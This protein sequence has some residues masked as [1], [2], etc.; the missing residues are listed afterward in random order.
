MKSLDDIG[1]LDDLKKTIAELTQKYETLRQAERA[2]KLAE[3]LEIIE[4]FQFTAEELGF[5]TVAPRADPHVD[6]KPSKRMLR[7][8]ATAPHPTTLQQPLW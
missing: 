2:G 1:S 4:T 3:A 8:E 7:D 6:K 5:T